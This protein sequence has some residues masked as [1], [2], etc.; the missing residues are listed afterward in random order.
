M[1]SVSFNDMCRFRNH[2]DGCWCFPSSSIDRRALR[3][4]LDD[5]L[6]IDQAMALLQGTAGLYQDLRTELRNRF[7]TFEKYALA[8]ILKVPPGIIP[9]AAASTIGREDA[10]L[11]EEELRRREQEVDR[12]L[13]DLREE[14]ASVKR[15]TRDMKAATTELDRLLRVNQKQMTC[16]KAV[17]TVLS[18]RTELNEEV[19]IISDKGEELEATFSKLHAVKGSC[20]DEMGGKDLEPHT[21]DGAITMTVEEDMAD[22]AIEKE[23]LRRQAASK[24]APAEDLRR[25][26]E[27]LGL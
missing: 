9:T 12:R 23:I 10:N 27:N 1:H 17:P 4:A 21:A 11:S 6:N 16:L 13:E 15:R 14:I 18:S 7:E 2:D 26:R 8:E 5:R 25:L 3:T 24:T 19:K 22:A 20:K